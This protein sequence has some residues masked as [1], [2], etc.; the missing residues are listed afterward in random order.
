[1]ARRAEYLAQQTPPQ[2]Q[3]SVDGMTGYVPPSDGTASGDMELRANLSGGEGRTP[4]E[5]FRETLDRYLPETAPTMPGLPSLQQRP[6]ADALPY[7]EQ[8]AI[9]PTESP[10]DYI[11]SGLRPPAGPAGMPMTSTGPLTVPAPNV[12][13]TTSTSDEA[14]RQFEEN[15]G[16]GG[17]TG[18][19]FTLPQGDMSG[20]AEDF[21][22][23]APVDNLPGAFE[24]I[25]GA[26]ALERAGIETSR[27]RQP[28]PLPVIDELGGRRRDDIATLSAAAET[29]EDIITSAP[30]I[31]A[32]EVDVTS[33]PPAVADTGISALTATAAPAA[34]V[35]AMAAPSVAGAAPTGGA[36]SGIAGAAPAAATSFEQEI[37]NAIQRQ[38]RRAEQDKWLALAQVGL[39][40]MTSNSPTFLGALGEGGTAGLQALVGTRDANEAR[41]M[42]LAQALEEYRMM[43]SERAAARAGAGRPR[44]PAAPSLS[45]LQ[46][47]RDALMTTSQ[48]EFGEDVEVPASGYESQVMLL[49][50]MIAQAAMA[51]LPQ[52]AP[53]NLADIV[54]Q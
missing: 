30:P 24:R 9:I 49:D 46:N 5:I 54:G 37:L 33:A 23:P 31:V 26:P 10:G 43:Q 21:G 38:E 36:P 17:G 2:A 20:F 14:M 44:A 12:S 6:T 28:A 19:S 18:V 29:P 25:F 51:G 32:P 45:D 53:A 42:E 52:Q 34:A 39:G 22:M 48:N 35:P 40:M 3:Q 4:T 50:Q 1:M 47:R 15:F 16:I 8:P 41:R 11:P 27:T 13:P 7:V